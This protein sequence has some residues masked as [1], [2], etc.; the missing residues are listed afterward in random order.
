MG[1]EMRLNLKLSQQLVMTPQLQQAIKLLQLSRVEL[2]ELVREEMLE[3]PVLEDDM[4]LGSTSPTKE[5]VDTQSTAADPPVAE[6]AAQ[7]SGEA[8][9]SPAEG[10]AVN[11]IDWENYLDTYQSGPPSGGVRPGDDDLPSL[12]QT[13]TKTESLE[14]HLMWQ[15]RMSDLPDEQKAIGEMILGNIDRNGYI[16]DTPLEDIAAEAECTVEEAESVLMKIQGFDPVGVGARSLAE[17]MF[18]QAVHYGQDDDLLVKMI[19]SHLGN[20]EK[21]NYQAIARD[22]KEPLEEIYEAAK[23]II[24]FD[25]R[26]GRQYN[27]D[28]PHYITPDVYI[29]K[30]GDKYFVVPNDDGLPKLKISNFYRSAMD[31]SKSAKDYLQDKLRSAQWLIRSIHQR[32]R[33][34]IK[35]T[36]SILKFQREFFEKGV[37]HLKPLIL[38]DV[39]EDIG[40]HESTIS[41]V[42]TNKYLHTPQGIYELKFFFNSGITRTNGEDL[43]SQAVKSKIKKIIGQED[44]KKPLSDQKIVE[45]LKGSSIDI[46][47]RTVAKYREQLGILSSSKRKQ[48]F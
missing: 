23:V 46:A 45:A 36:E 38:R 1:M 6:A 39:A 32:Q 7:E 11:E 41:R 21:K 8:A 17:C 2:V 10:P 4:E 20:L 14:D 26:P 48:V 35:V 29:H 16:K 30:V 42:T 44:P 27:S 37:A 15:L 33:T 22:L 5:I 25:P 13:L 12:E 9:E 47:R 34:I 43:A 31:G 40:M 18:I 19:R 28:D 3:N 24:E